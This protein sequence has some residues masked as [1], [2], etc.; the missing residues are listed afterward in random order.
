MDKGVNSKECCLHSGQKCRDVEPE[1][2][3]IHPG[4]IP[5]FSVQGTKTCEFVVL[6]WEFMD[7]QCN[8]LCG[9]VPSC[10]QS[11]DMYDKRANGFVQ[12]LSKDDAASARYSSARTA[13]CL[14]PQL[15]RC[16]AALQL[17]ML[18]V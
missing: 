5:F 10:M 12:R 4:A 1:A 17:Y 6:L 7:S 14:V 11:Q 13:V 2:R 15:G 18:L 8:M 3:S 9:R 16:P